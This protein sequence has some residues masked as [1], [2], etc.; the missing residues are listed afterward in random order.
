MAYVMASKMNGTSHRAHAGS[1]GPYANPRMFI[2]QP[3]N[4]SARTLDSNNSKYNTNRSSTP[5]D[6]QSSPSVSDIYCNIWFKKILA[7]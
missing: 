2:Q 3:N 6:S 4:M 7:G 5:P 1:N